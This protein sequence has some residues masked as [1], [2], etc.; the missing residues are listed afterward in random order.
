MERHA[1]SWQTSCKDVEEFK[2][3]S[4]LINTFDVGTLASE[5]AD[6]NGSKSFHIL[7]IAADGLQN[8]FLPFVGNEAYKKRK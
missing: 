8:K 2:L 3:K 7:V 5:I 6:T 1:S 4:T